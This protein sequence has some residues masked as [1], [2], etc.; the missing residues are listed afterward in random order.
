MIRA[1]AKVNLALQVEPR[2]SDGF[3]PLRGLFQSISLCDDVE[4]EASEEDEIVI[5]GGWAPHDESNLAWRAL[6]RVR[7]ETDRLTPMRLSITKR[8]PAEAGLGGA[9]ADAAVALVAASRLLGATFDAVRTIG[10]DLGSDVPFA[11]VGGTAIVAGRGELVS[12]RPSLHGFA[13]ALVVPPA[14][15]STADVYRAWD[16]LDEPRG[17]EVKATRLPPPLRDYAPLRNDLYPA[18]VALAPAVEEWRAE[19]A[20]RWDV[21]VMMTGSGSCLFGMFPTLEEAAG[22]V[23]GVPAG[24][25]FAEAASPVDQGWE[26]A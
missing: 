18:A 20:A 12:P 24:V 26:E 11:L 13:F 2:N 23:D 19:L 16:E 5:A 4:L 1:F 25:R 10:P 7:E 3:H 6:Q 15:L 8:I 17:P 21:P 14:E 22:A 9:S